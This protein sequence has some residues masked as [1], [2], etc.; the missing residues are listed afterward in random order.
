MRAN[1]NLLDQVPQIY[2][3]FS[4]IPREAHRVTMLPYTQSNREFPA[5]IDFMGV[6]Q[7]TAPGKEFDWMA[8][9]TAM[10]LVTAGQQPIF[11]DDK[12][13][14]EALSQTNLD[15]GQA[16]FLPLEARGAISA[17]EQRGARVLNADFAQQKISFQTDAPGACLTVISQTHYPAWKAY[18]DGR[19]T[20]IWRANY[21]FQAVE[22]PAGRHAVELR[23]EDGRF[24]A[25]L[26]L[27]GLGLLAWLGL[28]LRTSHRSSP[29]AGAIQSGSVLQ[30][31]GASARV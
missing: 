9:P 21:A 7:A 22:V 27:S 14:F 23:Y 11:G 3:F 2:G 30:T 10:P 4:L 28:W 18:V 6:S 29:S 8:R 25:G 20:K 16:V 31:G 17:L 26:I 1:C 12:A 24:L 19:P 15:L 5:L 13:V